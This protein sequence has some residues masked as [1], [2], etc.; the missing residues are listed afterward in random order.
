[1]VLT[2]KIFELKMQIK[3][4]VEELQSTQLFELLLNSSQE[5]ADR[6]TKFV[7]VIAEIL[8]TT[9]DYFP[10][11]TRHDAHHGFRVVRRL[12]QI[13]LPNCLKL[14]TSEVFSPVEIFLLIAAAYAHD[15]GMTVFPNEEDELLENLGLTKHENWKIDPRLQEYLRREHSKRGGDYI[16]KNYEKF[17]VPKNLTHI[18]DSM[19]KAH[20]F[21]VS[22]LE[23]NIPS[24]VA[25]LE[26][27]IDTR[28]LAVLICVADALEFSDTRVMDGVLD[29]IKID[30]SDSARISYQENMKHICLGDSLAIDEYGRVVV[31]GSFD[32]VDVLALA[33]KTF[34]QMEEWIQGYCDI[35]RRSKFPRLK[36]NPEPFVRKFNFTH[37]RFERLGIRLNKRKVIDLIAS[38]AVWNAN[39]GIAV[40]ELIQNAIEAC[41]FRRFHSGPADQY[42]PLVKVK[43]DRS[44]RTISIIDNGCGMSERTILNNFLTVGS[45]R[46][47]ESSY[48][49]DTYAPIARF[50]IG[51]W[52]VFTIAKN[53]HIRTVAFEEYRGNPQA[54]NYGK[55][56]AFDVSLAELK[57]YTV[58]IPINQACGT[59]ITLELREDIEFDDVYIQT[60]SMLLCS[61]IPVTFVFDNEQIEIPRNIPE[62]TDVD[63]LGSRNQALRAKEV[64]VF[65]WTGQLGDTELSLGLAYLMKDGK[66]TFC[67]ASSTPILMGVGGILSSKASICGLSVFTQHNSFCF[68][69]NRVG[70]FFANRLTPKDI[71]F[72]LDRQQIIS[73][74]ASK[75]YEYEIESLVHQGYRAFLQATNSYS[76]ED[77]ARLR[78]EAAMNGGNVYDTFTES[79]LSNAKNNYPDLL[80]F[81]LFPLNQSFNNPIYWDLRTLSQQNGRVFF[82]Q[83]EIKDTNGRTLYGFTGAERFTESIYKFVH[84]YLV[85]NGETIEHT[86]VMETNR[87]ASMLFDADPRSTVL[88]F[89]IKTQIGQNIILYL[90]SVTLGNIDYQTRIEE[91]ILCSIRGRWS[92]TIYLRSFQANKP[93]LLLGRHRILIERSSTLAEHLQDLYNDGKLVKLAETIFQLSE[94]EEGYCS[95]EIRQF[96]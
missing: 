51:F 37:G 87:L 80:S 69:L 6:I 93:F 41:R 25:A 64:Q 95:E 34:D 38:N 14:G 29:R 7:E 46:S 17:G 65:T 33:H 24:A 79:E 11:Y 90:Q 85:D 18:L 68:D 19:M 2:I 26:V 54:A 5:Y 23:S 75:K 28:Q 36:L 10:Y 45:S 32:E 42:S 62:I 70:L 50:G 60:K 13:C 92:G 12:E 66:A 44:K 20:N 3:D 82:V 84:Q 81:K 94:V 48:I 74:A 58:F 77:I 49:A 52:S 83:N 76:P 91:N 22:E 59:E 78:D 89:N 96:L 57:D 27:I 71:E 9:Q 72:S 31:N 88:L 35:N 56:V 55:G 61:E 30:D 15:L 8:R 4:P 47:K 1:M 67:M 21:S 86:Y 40:R 43:F 53:V 73:N 39:I 16:N 63:V